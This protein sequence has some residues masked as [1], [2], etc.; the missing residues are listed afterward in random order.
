MKK[1][2]ICLAVIMALSMIGGKVNAVSFGDGGVELQTV[3]DNITLGPNP[4]ISSINVLTDEIPDCVDSYWSIHGSGGSVSTVVM[5][6]AQWAGTNSFGIY[7]HAN[8]MNR[9]QIFSGGATSGSQSIMSVLADGSVFVN[10]AD[11]GVDFAGNFFGF[12][13]DSTQAPQPWTGGIWYSDTSLNAD[14]QDHMGVYQGKGIDTIQVLPFAPGVRDVDE[15]TFAFEG[16][17]AMHWGNQ[18]GINDGYP[19]WSDTEPNFTDFVVMVES[20]D[21]MPEPATLL[22]FGLG[23]IGVAGLNRKG[24]KG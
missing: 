22:L 7:D 10:L 21:P 13:L 18:N 6:L 5:E 3:L 2:I 17:H 1:F 24:F 12:Y 4:G 20:I 8:P 23:L 16:L 15:Y 14:Q 19:E 11:S 9:V